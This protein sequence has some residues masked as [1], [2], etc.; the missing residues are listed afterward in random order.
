MRLAGWLVRQSALTALYGG[1]TLAR[2]LLCGLACC[3]RYTESQMKFPKSEPYQRSRQRSALQAI[4]VA[5][6]AVAAIGLPANAGALKRDDTQQVQ[7]N[8]ASPSQHAH[9]VAS[10]WI[11]A[12][13]AGDTE[14][15]L[16]L[17]HLPGSPVHQRAVQADLDVMS[18]LLSQRGVCVEPIAQRQAGHWALSAWRLDQPAVSFSPVLEPVML[19]HASPDG[20]FE[21]SADWLVMP[22]GLGE[23]AAFQP[24]YNADHDALCDWFQTLM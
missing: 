10:S 7:C 18:D 12:L 5:A 23:D 24:L 22:Q 16:R 20:L 14:A 3:C 21:S 8:D 1:P 19:Y 6:T 4:V 13:F 9:R 15:A 2:R 11:D 17:M